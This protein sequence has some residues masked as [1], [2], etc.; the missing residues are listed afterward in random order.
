MG[1]GVL[2]IESWY[3]SLQI[4]KSGIPKRSLRGSPGKLKHPLEAQTP[5]I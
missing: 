1:E 4:P 5:P 2:I 3:K